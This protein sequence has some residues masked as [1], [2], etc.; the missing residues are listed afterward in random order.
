MTC[1]CENSPKNA[2]KICNPETKL[3]GQSRALSDLAS[4]PAVPAQQASF[5]Y[6]HPSFPPQLWSHHNSQGK[7]TQ[8]EQM[9]QQETEGSILSESGNGMRPV[10]LL[11]IKQK[12]CLE[13]AKNAFEQQLCN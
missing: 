8:K 4:L 1:G 13:K 6:I 12:F 9:W 2:T 5:G 10:A 7:K 11:I 3:P